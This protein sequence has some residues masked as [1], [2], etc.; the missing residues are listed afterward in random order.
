MNKLPQ[1]SH[2][3]PPTI[4]AKFQQA[5]K[6]LRDECKGILDA[7]ASLA[8]RTIRFGQ[9]FRDLYE[10][11][12]KLDGGKK[13]GIH[14]EV[15]RAQ[16][17]DLVQT[18]SPSIWSKWN[19]IGEF[20]PKLLPYAN[21]LPSTRDALYATAQIIEDGKSLKSLI[22]N[23]DIRPDGTVREI[24]AIHKKPKKQQVKGI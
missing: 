7:N 11:A 5:V 17:A 22:Q 18:D 14:Y 15:M 2:A 21:K 4:N 9:R 19:K 23:K 6:A 3:M 24:K 16:L 1:K 10:Q 8:E 12:K 20:A 13:E